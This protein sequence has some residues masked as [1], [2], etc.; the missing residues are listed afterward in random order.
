M[1][2][3]YKAPQELIPSDPRFGCG[4]SLVPMQH[5][6]A[7]LDAGPHMMGTSHRKKAVKGLCEDIQKGLKKY[8]EVP[9]DF[10]VVLGNGGATLLFDM[11]GLGMVEK[12]VAHFTCG[13]FSDKWY[14]CSKAIPWIEAVVKNVD[15]GQG[16]NPQY[17]EGAD[18]VCATLNE[19][20]T[21]V[22]F[23]QLPSLPENCL[24]AVDA[25]S[26]AGQVPLDVKK[27]DVFFFSPQKVFASEGGLFIAILSPKARA[28]ALKI[29]ADKSRYVPDI[30]SWVN[31]I[32]NSDKHQTYNTPAIATLF[33]LR[34]QVNLMNQVGYQGVC[35]EARKKAD[36]LYQWA[37]SKPYLTPYVKDP[38]FQ[39]MAVATID[40]D[41]KVDTSALISVL[42]KS[43]AVYGIDAYR[44]LGRNQFR[45]GLF[46]NIRYD[47]VVKLTKLLDHAIATVL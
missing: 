33:L 34:E 37:A 1:F 28:R 23:N 9:D 17:V 12:K 20:S 47:D 31:A 45:I 46:H 14:K 3:N 43:K 27:T 39:S 7:L 6:Q 15:Y 13:E 29:A 24:M 22:I 21:G 26:G 41:D 42:E 18:M 10:S 40:V 2:E 4:P 8:F 16:V 35:Q 38:A 44:K 25:T 11:I 36:F 30:M 5:L 32:D 19:T